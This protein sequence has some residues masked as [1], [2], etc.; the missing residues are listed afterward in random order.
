MRRTTRA[1]T[2]YQLLV[3]LEGI[4]PPIWRRLLVPGET[5]LTRLHH[6]LQ[7]AMGWGEY[8]EHGFRIDGTEYGPRTIATGPIVLGERGLSLRY[9]VWTAPAQFTY[10]CV[11]VNGKVALARALKLTDS[12]CRAR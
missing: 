10:L 2:L 11:I 3:T 6:I 5:T 12:D 7:T 4:E 1:P 8:H 9:L